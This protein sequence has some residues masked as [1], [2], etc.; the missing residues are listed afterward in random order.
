MIRI[1]ITA[2]SMIEK[3][4]RKRIMNKIKINNVVPNLIIGCFEIIVY[5][6]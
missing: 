2:N 5:N 6:K 1:I 3:R 4:K